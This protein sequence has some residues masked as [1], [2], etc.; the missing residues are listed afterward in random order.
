MQKNLRNIMK[1]EVDSKRKNMDSAIK[2]FKQKMQNNL[3]NNNKK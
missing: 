2:D 1:N 3:Q